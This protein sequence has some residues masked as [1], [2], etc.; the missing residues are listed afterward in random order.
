M[1]HIVQFG[2]G[3]DDDAIR[4][5]IEE[6]AEKQILKNIEDDVQSTLFERDY[7]G[8][9]YKK[10]PTDYLN[11]KIDEFLEKH[12]DKILEMASTKLADKLARSKRGK[13]ILETT[14]N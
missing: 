13:E 8:K 12:K 7:Y 4:K 1:E 11:R 10:V 2:I 14:T 9:N 6:G 5:R 3:I